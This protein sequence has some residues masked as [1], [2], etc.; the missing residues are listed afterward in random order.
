MNKKLSVFLLSAFISAASAPFAAADIAYGDRPF[1]GFF[2]SN[3][4]YANADESHYGF[5]KQTFADP[6]DNTLIHELSGGVGVYAATAID[7]VYYAAPYLYES[8]MSMPTP[9][10]LFS[11]NIYTGLVREIGPWSDGSTDLKPS[12]MTYDVKNDRILAACYGSLEGSGI[13]EIDRNTGKMSL[14]C[15]PGNAGGVI[16]AD[17]F[18]RIF[19]IN[20]QGEL[21]QVDPTRN[22]STTVIYRIPYNYLSANQSLEFDFTSGKLYWAS[23]TLENP[24]GDKGRSTWLVEITLPSISADMDYSADMKGY[25][26]TEVGEVGIYSRF[27]GLYIPYAT[28][29]FEAPGFATDLKSASSDDGSFCTISFKVPEKTF[30]GEPLASVDGYDIY[31][32]GVRIYTGKGT[33]AAGQEL[34]YEDKEVPVS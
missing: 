28:G 10:P 34:T 33:F 2:L 14:V 1:Y 4:G 11:Y 26:Y 19:T 9:M 23:N 32:D 15:N 6:W 17:A 22:N 29:G 5:A 18:G 13:Y 25:S 31:R 12:D 20:H 24:H 16:A 8:S 30:G 7:G 27:M 3:G 21:I